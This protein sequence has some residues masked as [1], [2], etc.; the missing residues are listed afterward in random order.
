VIAPVW[1]KIYGGAVGAAGVYIKHYSET[2]GTWMQPACFLKTQNRLN[3]VGFE[4]YSDAAATGNVG[5]SSRLDFALSLLSAVCTLSKSIKFVS[6][7]N[8]IPA[9]WRAARP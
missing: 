2:R 8:N 4:I 6:L 3:S 9:E 5:R 7:W 1:P